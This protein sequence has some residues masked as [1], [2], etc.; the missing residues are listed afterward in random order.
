MVYSQCIS[1]KQRHVWKKQYIYIYIDLFIYLDLFREQDPKPKQSCST[2]SL[3]VLLL[4]FRCFDCSFCATVSSPYH[5]NHEFSEH[6]ETSYMFSIGQVRCDH[7]QT[8]TFDWHPGWGKSWGKSLL[9]LQR[10]RRNQIF[11]KQEGT[12]T[13]EKIESAAYQEAELWETPHL[14]TTRFRRRKPEEQV[15][16][17]EEVGPI[18]KSREVSEDDLQGQWFHIV[19]II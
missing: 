9:F 13:W 1:V 15:K 19:M 3:R 16:A 8:F 5:P 6:Q 14:L 17:M 18:S 7:Q 11:Q 10:L 2:S 4:M 12:W